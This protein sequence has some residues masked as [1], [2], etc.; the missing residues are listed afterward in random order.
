MDF[1]KRFAPLLLLLIWLAA[2]SYAASSWKPP[3]T[4]DPQKIVA[5]AEADAAAGR[6]EDALAKHVWFHTNAL[7][8]DRS[9]YGV[10][11]SFALGAWVRLGAVYPPALEKL[12]EVRAEDAEM[13]R[14]NSLEKAGFHIFN[15]I[16]AI[17]KYLGEDE[18]TTQLFQWLDTHLPEEAKRDYRLAERALV[19]S[20]QYELIGKYIDAKS[21]LAELQRNF[22][23]QLKL[24]SEPEL[25]D[26]LRQLAQ[27]A[28]AKDAAT[29]V[30]LLVINGRKEEAADIA[31]KAGPEWMSL[32][33]Q[34]LLQKALRGEVPAGD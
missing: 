22:H 9:L 12:R 21:E 4:P 7:K 20:K 8:Y 25:G 15:E 33:F 30:A 13:V 26:R 31:K 6:Y 10:R 23:E 27:K 28:F 1:F 32:E 5:E 34:A 11:L 2:D 19:K 17:N 24:A 16:A 29:L 14:A 18:N 3:E